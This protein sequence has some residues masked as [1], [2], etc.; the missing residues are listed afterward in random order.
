MEFSGIV[1][2]KGSAVV[3]VSVG[4][5]VFGVVDITRLGALADFVVADASKV[6]P[7]PPT[8]SYLHAAA[9]P[10]AGSTALQAWTLAG[11]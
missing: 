4:D 5:R 1:M 8:V 2:A 3:T 7:I 9:L 10:V 11:P 6:V